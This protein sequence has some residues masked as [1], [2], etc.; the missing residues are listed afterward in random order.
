MCQT[1]VEI[2]P[3]EEGDVRAL[4]PPFFGKRRSADGRA[5][6]SSS[7]YGHLGNA[8]NVESKE[9]TAVP[10]SSELVPRALGGKGRVPPAKRSV[11]PTVRDK[12]C[13]L[14]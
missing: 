13:G 4:M 10:E 7:R 1:K 2:D 11:L 8:D 14:S 3:A 9:T 5:V 12:H 6:L